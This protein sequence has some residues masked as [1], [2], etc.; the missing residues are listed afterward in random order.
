MFGPHGHCHRL[1]TQQ[2]AQQ[3]QRAVL[4]LAVVAHLGLDEL[5]A[6]VAD[7]IDLSGDHRHTAI[8]GN[9]MGKSNK[10]VSLIG[11]LETCGLCDQR[12][13]LF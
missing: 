7:A 1:Q 9:I 12:G 6:G 13:P 2:G 3:V 5:A 8:T 4:C 10:V 11:K